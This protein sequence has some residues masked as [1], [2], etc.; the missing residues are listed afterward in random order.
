MTSVPIIQRRGFRPDFF[1]KYPCFLH[2]CRC[3]LLYVLPSRL[4]LVDNGVKPCFVV[5]LPSLR[6][7]TVQVKSGFRLKK[8]TEGMCCLALAEIWSGLVTQDRRKG[9]NIKRCAASDWR[10]KTE[11]RRPAVTPASFFPFLVSFTAR[12]VYPPKPGTD[13]HFPPVCFYSLLSEDTGFANAAL[14]VW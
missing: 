7:P 2:P 14:R 11:K 13:T 1:G 9:G 5:S 10:G 3:R 12:P 6:L 4:N 8:Q